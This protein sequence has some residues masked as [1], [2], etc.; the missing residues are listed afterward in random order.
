MAIPEVTDT[1]INFYPMA[2]DKKI[3]QSIP[4]VHAYDF[5][6]QKDGND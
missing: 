5:K 4:L 6:L 3:T 1:L 2:I